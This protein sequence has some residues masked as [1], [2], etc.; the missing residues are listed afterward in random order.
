MHDILHQKKSSRLLHIVDKDYAGTRSFL[1]L[2]KKYKRA[3]P[4]MWGNYSTACALKQVLTAQKPECI[5]N[6]LTL[7]VLHNERRQGMVCTRSNATKIGFNCLS[8]RVQIVTN[9]MM[10]NWMDMS[11]ERFRKFAKDMFINDQLLRT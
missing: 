8:N 2:H 1:S 5:V 3:T 10:V 7:N 11:K 4:E 6:G 9:K